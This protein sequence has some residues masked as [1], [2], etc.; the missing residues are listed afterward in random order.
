MFQGGSQDEIRGHH[1][2]VINDKELMK[3]CRYVYEI[4]Y[5]S[6]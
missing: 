3:P 2:G 6:R 4:I 1:P 5:I